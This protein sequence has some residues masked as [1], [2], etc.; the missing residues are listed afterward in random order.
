MQS[1]SRILL[2][3][4]RDR[5]VHAGLA[6]ALS[7]ARYTGASLELFLCDTPY[8]KAAAGDSISLPSEQWRQQRARE[9]LRSLR[10]GIVSNEVAIEVQ[11]SSADSLLGGVLERLRRE[12][13][14]LV[15]RTRGLVSAAATLFAQRLVQAGTPIVLTQ[16]QPWQP[17]P[18]FMTALLIEHR[19]DGRRPRALVPSAEL[20]ELLGRS[21][22]ARMDYVIA[23]D[24]LLATVA[25]RRD[26]DLI[27]L[28][29]SGAEGGPENWQRASG[30]TVQ[31]DLTGVGAD[32]LFVGAARSRNATE[33]ADA[34]H[35]AR[36]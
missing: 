31:P 36:L 17:A 15:V 19:A 7:L 13:A 34:P 18:H 33:S 1:L 35:L 12:P 30:R 25:R 8:Y 6:K 5:W 20:P 24:T 10:Q 3:V 28:T 2:V 32:V 29:V 26:Y 9:Y 22:G 27:A 4:E 11:A 23:A 16:G 14:Q 21:C